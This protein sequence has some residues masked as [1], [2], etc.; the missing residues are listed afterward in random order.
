MP[1]PQNQ[2]L[3]KSTTPQSDASQ[4]DVE[5][6]RWMY[7]DEAVTATGKSEKTLKRYIKKGELQS[8]RMGKQINS[9]VQIWI[10]SNFVT[11]RAHEE[12][13]LEDPDIFDS[14]AQEVEDFSPEYDDPQEQEES[15]PSEEASHTDQYERLVKLMVGEFTVQLDRQKEVLFELR[16]ELEQKEI[17]LRL[18]PDLEAKL[19]QKE[20]DAHVQ[21]KALEKNIESLQFKFEEQTKV[22]AELETDRVSQTKRLEE[23]KE[24][25][26]KKLI[27]LE[28]IRKENEQLKAEIESAKGKKNWLSWFLGK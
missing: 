22:V 27:I 23:L 17:Q 21:T 14:E 25:E 15:V 19:H 24:E 11:A 2:N 26:E 5:Q 1:T 16:R 6:G 7:Y 28:E 3:A 9:P 10:P 13:T 20:I 8:R 18:L 4:T 12:E